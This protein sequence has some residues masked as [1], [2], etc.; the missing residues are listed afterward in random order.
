M[1]NENITGLLLDV[2]SGLEYICQ[3]PIIITDCE[4]AWYQA[5]NHLDSILSSN[6]KLQMF[7][8]Y[9]KAEYH[10]RHRIDPQ[11]RKLREYLK[12]AEKTRPNNSEP[13]EIREKYFYLRCKCEDWRK[14]IDQYYPPEQ[15]KQEPVK[16]RDTDA[17][18]RFASQ[19]L[20]EVKQELVK[21]GLI[22]DGKWSAGTANFECLVKE[23][24]GVFGIETKKGTL[25]RKSCAV[26]V[27]FD[28]SLDSARSNTYH[29]Q[30]SPE[31]KLIKAIC[32][33]IHTKY[34]K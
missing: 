16:E 7:V 24:K 25:D 21:A 23:F 2:I 32:G 20:Q 6:E 3:T 13:V 33:E 4:F 8:D 1:E 28:G 9:L 5:G 19:E 15:S 17:D 14:W 29:E 31:A 11:I 30:Q 18:E 12:R 34:V 27:G 26:F 10:A 22:K